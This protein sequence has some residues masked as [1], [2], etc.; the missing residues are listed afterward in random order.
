M[1]GSNPTLAVALGTIFCLIVAAHPASAGEKAPVPLPGC[2][3]VV[4]FTSVTGAPESGK[5]LADI[6]ARQFRE[7]G[8]AHLIDRRDLTSFLQSRKLSLPKDRDAATMGALGLIVQTPAVLDGA[9]LQYSDGTHEGDVGVEV[10]VLLRLIEART[11]KILWQGTG[12]ASGASL[13]NFQRVPFARVSERAIR[14]ALDNLRLSEV[15][16]SECPSLASSPLISGAAPESIITEA[17]TGGAAAPLRI[18]RTYAS[19]S[20]EKRSIDISE[21][22]VLH[23]NSEAAEIEPGMDDLVTEIA[24]ILH[25]NPDLRLII[26]GHTD[27]DSKKTSEGRF[28]VSYRRAVAI[29]DALR[30]RHDVNPKRMMIQAAGEK[31][32]VAPND[33]RF[34]RTLNRRVEFKFLTGNQ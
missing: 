14:R 15:P 1:K 34:N 8:A 29:Y 31:S 25:D 33:S 3:G 28:D 2:V 18:V 6:A 26:E 20:G 30:K 5:I 16:G 17:T 32:P 27:L 21:V 19:A 24:S 7:R 12:H 23:F 4:E 11:H 9:V 22:R 10:E 13:F